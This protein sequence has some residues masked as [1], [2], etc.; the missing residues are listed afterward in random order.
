MITING[1]MG[2]GGGQVLRSSLGLSLVTGQPV[3]L[4]KIRA[5]RPRPGLMRQHLTAA[6]AA[7][8]V[9]GGSLEGDAIGSGELTF[10]PGRVRGGS[11]RFAVGTAGSATLVFQT[12]LPALLRADERSELL[13]EGGTHNQWAPPFDFLQR[14]FLPVLRRMGATVSA[15]LERPGFY[16]AGGGLFRVSVEPSGP[17]QPLELLERGTP[18]LRLARALVALLKPSIADRELDVVR[19]KLGWT[20]DELQVVEL[21]GSR[22]PG[23]MLALELGYD[24]VTE[25]IAGFGERG[26]TAERVARQAVGQ[27]KRYLACTAPVG[28][29]LADQLLIPLAL[30]GG[31]TFRTLDLTRHTTT[32]MEVVR[33]FLD[34]NFEAQER[35]HDDVVLSVS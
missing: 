4:E 30:A 32:N 31:G 17:L 21:Q 1:A 25:L 3:R 35:G 33:R 24:N 26:V 13:L 29:H 9:G 15:T 6:R 19:R 34:V 5:A 18:R 8:E 22:G 20:G 7:A 28:R 12:V 14:A 2:E 11:Y 16:P 27:A 10:R 23:N